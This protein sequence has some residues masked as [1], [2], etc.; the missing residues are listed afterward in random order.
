MKSRTVLL[1]WL[2]ALLLGASVFFLK[3]SSGGDHRNSTKR[4]PGQTLFENF[5]AKE[6]ATIEIKGTKDAVTLTQKDGKWTVAQRDNFPADSRKINE[7]LRSLTDLK[8]TQGIEAGPSAAANFGMD[9]SSEKPEEHGL[10]AI[11]KDA[12][13]K[14]LATL[15][16]GKNLDSASQSSPVGGGATGRF[17]RNHAD[18]SGFYAVSEVFGTASPDPKT[19]LSEDFVEIEKIQTISLSKPG[20]DDNDWAL[21]REEENGDFKFTDAFPGV[22]IDPATVTPLKSL[23]S[24]ARFDDVVPASEVEKRS[25][26]DKLQKVEITTFEGLTY[27]VT[28]QPA[29]PAGTEENPEEPPAAS[30]NY[31]M[32][33]EVSGDLPKERKKPADEKKEEA[34]AADKAF[35]ERSIALTETLEKTKALAGRTF[36]VSKFTVDSLLKSRTDL[37][38]K[39]PGPG[40]TAPPPAPGTSAFTPPIEIPAQ[41]APEAPSPPVEEAAPEAPTPPSEEP[42]STDPE[43]PKEEEVPQA[44]EPDL[45]AKE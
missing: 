14:E 10:T 15:S 20:S 39:G 45:P 42:K 21:T 32:T 30:D 2:V 22:Q 12:S 44:P 31:L 9:E 4:A 34:E 38:S 16:L 37:M 3:K 1:L 41:P 27:K 23:F 28:L 18:E 8:V 33:V 24:F 13:G 19:W 11:F 17:V 35:A 26:P 43:S 36:E 40:V 29:K 5:P 7:L 6:I 25:T